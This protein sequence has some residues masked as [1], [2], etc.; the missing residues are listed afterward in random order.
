MLGERKQFWVMLKIFL[1][2]SLEV[3][4]MGS[5]S[6]LLGWLHVAVYLLNR[7]FKEYLG[8]CMYQPSCMNTKDGVRKKQI[9]NTVASHGDAGIQRAL[10]KTG[11]GAKVAPLVETSTVV[12]IT[13]E[14]R[15][16]S[17]NFLQWLADRSL[18]SD[19]RIMRLKEGY[20]KEGSTVSVMGVVRRHENILM[21]V[22]PTEPLSTGCQWLRC[23]LPMYVEGLVLH[24][25]DNQNSEV[26]PV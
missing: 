8:V 7:H 15:D 1:M 23:L 12:D 16:L 5:L 3:L 17:P 10:V 26:I 21:I 13:K 14:N 11:Y 6:R 18:S 19:D 20:V 22:P 25:E 4:L 24:C 2:L 9:P